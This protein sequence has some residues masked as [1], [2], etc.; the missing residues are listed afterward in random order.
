M[1]LQEL[2]LDFYKAKTIRAALITLFGGMI[3]AV[4]STFS[5]WTKNS[6]ETSGSG[7]PAVLLSCGFFSALIWPIVVSVLSSRQ[8]DIEFSNRGWL[9]LVTAGCSVKGMIRAKGIV[10]CIYIAV[11]VICQLIL[12]FAICKITNVPGNIE[13]TWFTFHLLLWVVT[14]V[15]FLIVL[16]VSCAFENQIIPIILGM[17]NAFIALF[18]FLMR[19]ALSS[20]LYVLPWGYYSVIVP[21]Q[22]VG[23]SIISQPI[24][25]LAIVLFCCIG[26]LLWLLLSNRIRIWK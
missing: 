3:I 25:Y 20:T 7:Y 12:T 16:L 22:Q 26:Y 4:L 6:I 17:V 5:L 14:C 11:G 18:C 21:L 8:A 13:K 23:D 9:F 2:W 19:A 24:N 10:G 15:F 1:K